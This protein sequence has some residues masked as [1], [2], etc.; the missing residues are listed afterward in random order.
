MSSFCVDFELVYK[1]ILPIS[2]MYSTFRLPSLSHCVCF[3]F[4]VVQLTETIN[5]SSKAASSKNR[6][7][8]C[9]EDTSVSYV[10]VVLSLNPG[11]VVHSVHA[12]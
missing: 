1:N 8:M 6:L 2:Y 10:H 3:A 11:I 7:K 4:V 9:L 12:V 5:L